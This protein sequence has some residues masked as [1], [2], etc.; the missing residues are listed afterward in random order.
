MDNLVLIN[1]YTLLIYCIKI[2]WPT[3]L[4]YSAYSQESPMYYKLIDI[5]EWH[6]L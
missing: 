6:I 5:T 3:L 4:E 1:V 2:Q